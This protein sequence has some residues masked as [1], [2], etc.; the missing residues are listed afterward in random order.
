MLKTFKYLLQNQ[1]TDELGTW[2]VT[3][4]TVMIVQLMTL[5]R[6]CPFLRQCQIWENAN[7]LDFVES[8]ED[9]GLKMCN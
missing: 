7:T 8:F 3:L 6:P 1:R 2:Y 5:G 4:G 9:S